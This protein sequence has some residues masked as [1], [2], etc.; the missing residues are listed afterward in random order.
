MKQGMLQRLTIAASTVVIATTLAACGS[1]TAAAP[2]E[3]QAPTELAEP[4]TDIPEV[5]VDAGF[6]PYADELLM[7]AGLN[8]GY[9]DEVG[10][11]IAPEPYGIDT[12]LISS[13]TPLLNGQI[14]LGSGYAPAIVSQ[15]D[16]VDT[17]VTFGI[18]DVFYGYRI[19]APEGKYQTL[20]DF[21]SAGDSYEEA[22][23]KVLDQMKGQDVVL[24]DGVVPT[25]Y[26]L[27][28]EAGGSGLADWKVQ[29]LANPD[30]VRTAQAGGVDFV[31]PTGAV[32]IVR[33]Q[34]DGWEPLIDLRQ[35]I[36]NEPKEATASLRSTFSGYLTTRDYAEE[37]WDTILRVT[38]VMY[39]LI[40]EIEADPEATAADFVDY[41][42]SYTGSSLTAAELAQTFQGLYSVRNFEDAS[43]FYLDQGSDFFFDEVAGAQIDELAEQGVIG[44]NHGPASLS[45]AGQVYEALVRYREEADAIL[46][47]LPDGELKT[48]AQAQYDARNYLDAYRIAAAAAEQG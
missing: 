24:R 30:I 35:V 44:D 48:A 9:F 12:D 39:R 22:V 11:S 45:I 15:L 21:M 7:V 20:D 13:L 33:L 37:N 10:V 46:A 40:D 27:I 47:D 1:E 36:E 4:G 16:N 28:G 17:V 8:R 3:F 23:T 5:S 42:N 14:D 18:Q 2:E 43:E 31:S 38:S 41:V 26:N 6:S 19:L 25:F 34:G 29:Y 32:E